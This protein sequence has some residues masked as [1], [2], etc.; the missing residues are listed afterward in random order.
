MAVANFFGF[1]SWGGMRY[2]RIFLHKSLIFWEVGWLVG[3]DRFQKGED[4]VT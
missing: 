2:H 1:W 4:V 3:G